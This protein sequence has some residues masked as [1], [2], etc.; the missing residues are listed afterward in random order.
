MAGIA[1]LLALCAL[2]RSDALPHVGAGRMERLPRLTLWAWERPEDLRSVDPAT[3]AVAYLDRTVLV[4]DGVTVPAL[5]VL[6]RRQRLLTA[7]NMKRIAVVRI[8]VQPG[9]GLTDAMRVV[10]VR[11]ILE[12]VQP[13]TAALQVDF[14]ARRSERE[15][16]R[17]VL[18]DLR[19]KMPAKMPLSITALGS[20][21][22]HD[23]WMQG[24]PV[25]EAVPML[26][27]MEPDHV[28]AAGDV[29]A[30]AIREPLCSTSVGVSTEEP[31]PAELAGRRVY[32]FPDHGWSQDTLGQVERRVQ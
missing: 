29:D 2:V 23:R 1:A 17:Q 22:S 14:D 11:Q 4:G 10:V 5:R 7:E 21:C 25:D 19:G 13:E 12:A 26:F 3:T 24:L 30:F 28:K 27:R 18:V 8:E 15:W 9:L 32:V 6:P 16:Y 31:W 20:W